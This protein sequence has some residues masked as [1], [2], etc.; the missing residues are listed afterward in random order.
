MILINGWEMSNV[1]PGVHEFIHVSLGKVVAFN[2]RGKYELE[3]ECS[4]GT[5]HKSE[6]AHGID[7]LDDF[8]K[9]VHANHVRKLIKY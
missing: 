9:R 5:K 7:N 8:V 6:V 1:R 2:S 3:H 4:D